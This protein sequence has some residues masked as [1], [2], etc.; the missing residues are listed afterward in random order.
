LYFRN[1]KILLVITRVSFAAGLVAFRCRAAAIPALNRATWENVWMK[2]DKKNVPNLASSSDLGAGIH[3]TL[4]VMMDR[5]PTL[6]ATKRFDSF[7]K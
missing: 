5:V 1:A 4:R 3:A 7:L 2:P 6:H